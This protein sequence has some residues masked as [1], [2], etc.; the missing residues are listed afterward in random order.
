MQ[1]TAADS[2]KKNDEGLSRKESQKM[3]L[4][5]RHSSILMKNLNQGAQLNNS[6]SKAL[7]SFGKSKRFADTK[8]LCNAHAYDNRSYL[9]ADKSNLSPL[10]VK[11]GFGGS[12]RFK[13]SLQEY[14]SMVPS[15]ADYNVRRE[16]SPNPRSISEIAIA[17]LQ[18]SG[19]SKPSL[20]KIES[21]VSINKSLRS[22]G[23]ANSVTNKS[24]DHEAI[25][26]LSIAETLVPSPD[27]KKFSFGIGRDN[28]VPLGVDDI[29]KRLSN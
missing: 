26:A 23:G 7:F 10:A 8:V 20:T 25:K 27:G 15:G 11:K 12:S 17:G 19:N 3:I 16:F 28:C 2:P 6:K 24:L 29:F 13:D 5:S 21:A 9:R 18:K 4:N 14:R 22:V 1:S